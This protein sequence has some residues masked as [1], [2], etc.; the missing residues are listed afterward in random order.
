MLIF[1]EERK[2]G[3]PG[4]KPLWLRER[5]NKQLNSQEVPE[6]RIE[7]TNKKTRNRMNKVEVSTSQNTSYSM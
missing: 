2:T 3:E 7:P 4:K 5:T 1:Q 6:P